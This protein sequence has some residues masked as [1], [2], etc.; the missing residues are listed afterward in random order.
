MS[1]TEGNINRCAGQLQQKHMNCFEA[2]Y[3]TSVNHVKYYSVL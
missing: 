3:L 2:H 1:Q